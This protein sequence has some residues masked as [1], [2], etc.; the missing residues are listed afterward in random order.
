M[1]LNRNFARLALTLATRSCS[2]LAA[3]KSSVQAAE[4]HAIA[5][6]LAIFPASYTVH[7]HADSRGALA[8]IQAYERECSAR[9]R[10]RM[11]ARPLLQ[12]IA[13]LLS[14]P[15]KAGAVHGHH[16]KAHTKNSDIDSVGNRLADWQVTRSRSR[17]G[18]PQPLQLRELPVARTAN[19]TWRY[20]KNFR[21]VAA[22]CSLTTFDVLLSPLSK[23][24]H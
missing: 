20:I 10:L 3:G 17:P 8:G 16:V 4:L 6:A 18:E 2:A 24:P 14:V 13:H 22:A 9:Q 15:R 21:L 23:P 7:V 19:I 11:A 5:R 12:L 1:R